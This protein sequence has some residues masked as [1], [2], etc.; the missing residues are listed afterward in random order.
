MEFPEKYIDTEERILHSGQK[1]NIFYDVNNLLTD[2]FYLDYILGSVPFS[3]HYVGVATGGAIIAA[4]LAKV[5]KSKFSMIKDGGLKGEMPEEEWILVDDVLTTGSSLKEAIKI[6]GKNPLKIWVA[7]DRRVEKK[8]I[9][10]NSIFE[11]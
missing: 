2:S 10:V 7:V 4:L 9:E 8:E 5:N 3:E 11:I 1:S 6:I